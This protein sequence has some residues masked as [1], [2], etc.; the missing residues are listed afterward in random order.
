MDFMDIQFLKS[1]KIAQKNRKVRN[2]E[3]KKYKI[4]HL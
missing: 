1:N 2:D 3:K 4:S